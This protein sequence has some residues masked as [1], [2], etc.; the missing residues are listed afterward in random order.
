MLID[1]RATFRLLSDYVFKWLTLYSLQFSFFTHCP[2]CR[3]RIWNLCECVQ[4]TKG[5][6]MDLR[7]VI[8]YESENA[9]ESTYICLPLSSSVR[10]S[11]WCLSMNFLWSKGEHYWIEPK[12]FF[13]LILGFYYEK[14]T[15]IV[16]IDWRNGTVFAITRLFCEYVLIQHDFVKTNYNWCEILAICFGTN[17]PARH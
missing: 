10:L 5:L 16:R 8:S 11:I 9:S 6:E 1:I 2:S 4:C 7:F 15:H 12:V 3:K 13:L 17:R 14:L